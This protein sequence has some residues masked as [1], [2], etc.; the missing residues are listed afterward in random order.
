MA[1]PKV[2]LKDIKMDKAE[3]L[4]EKIAATVEIA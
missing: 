3:E 4:K 2:A 1:A